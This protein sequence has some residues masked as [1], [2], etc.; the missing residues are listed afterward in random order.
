LFELLKPAVEQ[1]PASFILNWSPWPSVAI[2]LPVWYLRDPSTAPYNE[3]VRHSCIAMPTE[4]FP[5]ERISRSKTIQLVCAYDYVRD[6]ST[7]DPRTKFGTYIVRVLSSGIRMTVDMQKHTCSYASSSMIYDTSFNVAYLSSYKTTSYAGLK[8]VFKIRFS[9]YYNF[10]SETSSTAN[11]SSILSA[12]EMAH[13][14]IPPPYQT[15]SQDSTYPKGISF[16]HALIEPRLNELFFY[17]FAVPYP[18]TYLNR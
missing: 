8:H 16:D 2:L 18:N 10:L 12:L 3:F 9:P 1:N 5:E 11:R 15:G 14:N 6:A 13:Y 7:S 17:A 4:H